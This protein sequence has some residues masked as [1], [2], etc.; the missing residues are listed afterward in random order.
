[1]AV[2]AWIEN[3]LLCK[4]HVCDLDHCQAVPLTL[5]AC[6]EGVLT[7]SRIHRSI[8]L[9]QD[10]LLE[11]GIPAS[12]THRKTQEHTEKHRKP[13]ENTGKIPLLS[14]LVSLLDFA[15]RFWLLCANCDW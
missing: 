8:F 2:Y 14:L 13:Q 6:T 15:S 5:K 10:F 4:L 12:E 9:F 3:M 7:Y 1:M 11:P